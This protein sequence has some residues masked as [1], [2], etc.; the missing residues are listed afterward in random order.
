MAFL[1]IVAVWTHI[2]AVALWI[3]AMFFGDP[4]SE[5][6]FSRLF[7]RKLNGIGWYAQGVL[8]ITGLFM[9][10]YRGITLE[11]LLSAEF[12]ATS[13]GRLVWI[14]IG[15]VLTL[16]LFQIMVGHKPSQLIYGYI[17]VAFAAVGVGVLLVRPMIF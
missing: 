6:F 15:L 8:W 16:A 14:K 5:R 9:L 4:H 13:W 2:I 10:H 11:R 17:L 1:Y 7:E 3:G 12:I